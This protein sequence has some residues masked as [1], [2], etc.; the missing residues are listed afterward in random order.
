MEFLF[1]TRCDL[2]IVNLRKVF[3]I[4]TTTIYC[5]CVATLMYAQPTDS[6]WYSNNQKGNRFEGFHSEKVSS[7]LD[8]VSFTLGE[9][10]TYE[11][12]NVP[13]SL[14]MR[15]FAPN[16]TTQYTL[17]AKKITGTGGYW[18]QDTSQSCGYGWHQ[19]GPWEVNSVLK[20]NKINSKDLGVIAKFRSIHS[21]TIFPVKVFNASK[22]LND[23]YYLVKLKSNNTVLK[24]AVKITHGKNVVYDI[25][26]PKIMADVIYPI[27]IPVNKFVGEGYY[28][29]EIRYMKKGDSKTTTSLFHFYH[30]VYANK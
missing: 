26:V 30:K 15:F 6:L 5:V 19:F 28:Q 27:K 8:I 14:F 25:A 12:F 1:S 7:K 10:P 9:I 20:P 18:M 3:C 23:E 4:S 2:I 11:S 24:M 13:S 21:D 16:P 22:S 29:V 17:R